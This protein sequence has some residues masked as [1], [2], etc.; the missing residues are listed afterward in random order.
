MTQ[1]KHK[2]GL[3][4]GAAAF[5][6]GLGFFWPSASAGPVSRRSV[7]ATNA[8]SS[9]ELA[10]HGR[11]DRRQPGV[12]IRTNPDP[13]YNP[14][15]GDYDA[16]FVFNSQN[17]RP[18]AVFDS[19]PRLEKWA[20]PREKRLARQVYHLIDALGEDADIASLECRSG[21]C[22]LRI[23]MAN[24]PDRPTSAE[25]P[26]VLPMLLQRQA[27]GGALAGLSDL[28]DGRARAEY[29]YFFDNEQRDSAIYAGAYLGYLEDAI[30]PYVKRGWLSEEQAKRL[31]AEE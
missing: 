21:S 27:A 17:L 3:L 15:S 2:L 16:A 28:P 11:E 4:I 30:A 14:L 7:E 20:R 29:Y 6:V 18:Q 31:L 22:R 24:P 25:S 1:T 10:D 9:A 19:E 8:E 26:N 5:G 13:V 23:D 12:R